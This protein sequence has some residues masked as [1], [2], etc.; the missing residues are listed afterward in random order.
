[1]QIQMESSLKQTASQKMIQSAQI[2]QRN[3]AELRQYLQELSLENPL[4]EFVPPAAS[5][6]PRREPS[7][8]ADEQNPL[9]DRQERATARDIWNTDATQTLSDVL[10]FQLSA[11][12]L[13]P[14][15]HR[16]LEHMIYNLDSNGYLS[17]ALEDIQTAFGSDKV[18]VTEALALLQSLEPC[19]VGAR[20]LSECLCIQLRRLHPK[21]LF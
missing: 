15:K 11:L 10:L 9:Y 16:I 2:L 21:E 6:A 18:A 8:T 12:A 13:R 5:D 1:M 14:G 20:D 3:T 17:V 19:G 7:R 4:M